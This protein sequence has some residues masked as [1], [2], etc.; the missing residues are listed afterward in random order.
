MSYDDIFLFIRLIEI[1]TFSALARSL[2]TTQGTISRR[3]KKLEQDL[4]VQLLTRSSRGPLEMTED[5]QLLYD[6]FSKQEQQ[7]GVALEEIIKLQKSVKGILRISVPLQVFNKIIQPNLLEFQDR[8]PMA[9]LVISYNGGSVDLLKDNY[10]IA[11]SMR[12][13]KSQNTKIKLLKKTKIKLF[14]SCAYGEKYGIPDSLNELINH[15]VAGHSVDGTMLSML[16][17]TN[18]NTNID[19]LVN[20][21]PSV[22]INNA[23]H[24][25]DLALSGNF[26]I[27]AA[28]IFVQNGL[29]FK[30]LV[31]VL[32]DYY[33]GET[34]YFLV[35]RNAVH[36]RLEMVF[37]Q[38]IQ[39][40]FDRVI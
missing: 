19:E 14:A 35:R 21:E 38:F 1:G 34:N 5:G 2:N 25:I 18:I 15:H 13:P 32:P 40:C 3:I 28:D 4:D 27:S 6:R 17:A 7:L 20:Y 30:E 22:F 33:F 12:I 31:P 9:K 24:N 23:L 26:I 29:I 8:Y 11:V 39:D 10:D 37:A 36:S 16:Q